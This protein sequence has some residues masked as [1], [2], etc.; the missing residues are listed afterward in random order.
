MNIKKENGAPSSIIIIVQK[1]NGLVLK[2][3]S[4]PNDD[5]SIQILFVLFCVV[6]ELFYFLNLLL[7]R[8][9]H[10]FAEN[11]RLFFCLFPLELEFRF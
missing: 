9:V 10:D 6:I 2:L 3:G 5:K 1:W 4:C 11:L 8:K 7:P